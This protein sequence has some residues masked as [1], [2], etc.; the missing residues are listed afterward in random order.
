MKS[1]RLPTR[2]GLAYPPPLNTAVCVVLTILHEIVEVL[3][4]SMAY[5]TIMWTSLSAAAFH[6]LD[7]FNL[8]TSRNGCSSWV[9][10]SLDLVVHNKLV[11]ATIRERTFTVEFDMV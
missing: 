10:E 8:K 7:S 9:S 6:L 3:E 1:E 2:T 11:V 5:K 4:Q